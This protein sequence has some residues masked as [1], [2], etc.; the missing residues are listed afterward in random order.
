ML[1]Y[2]SSYVQS[3]EECAYL[4]V[5][6]GLPHR[7]LPPACLW[8][9]IPPHDSPLHG[10]RHAAVRDVYQRSPERVSSQA[11]TCFRFDWP[12]VPYATSVM[13][14]TA[15]VKEA[16]DCFFDTVKFHC[17]SLLNGSWQFCWNLKW[18]IMSINAGLQI[19]AACWSSGA[20]I[21]SLT[22]DQ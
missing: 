9:K 13:K 8:A 4:C 17:A 21:S 2:F 19:M 20:S 16:I 18:H 22:A 7:A 5:H 10:H 14:S 15:V 11:Q 1:F 12:R 3:D 6:H